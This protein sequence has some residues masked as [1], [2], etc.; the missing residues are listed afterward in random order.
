[1]VL[2]EVASSKNRK[3][4]KALASAMKLWTLLCDSIQRSKGSYVL[5]HLCPKFHLSY[6]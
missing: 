5:A 2:G 6:L 1:M 4:H 3:A